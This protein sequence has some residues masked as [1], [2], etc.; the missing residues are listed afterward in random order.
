MP[1]PSKV[2]LIKRERSEQWYINFPSALARSMDFTR[3]E[4]IEWSIHDRCTLVL[5]RPDAPPSTLESGVRQPDTP[6]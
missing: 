3:G 4:V 6:S 2:Q 5:R 1:Y